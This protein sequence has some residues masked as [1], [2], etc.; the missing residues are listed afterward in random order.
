MLCSLHWLYRMRSRLHFTFCSKFLVCSDTAP[1]FRLMAAKGGGTAQQHRFIV[2]NNSRGASAAS[3][4][5]SQNA[6]WQ[7]AIMT[8]AHGIVI[9]MARA[10]NFHVN[11]WTTWLRQRSPHKDER[12]LPLHRLNFA[13]NALSAT[14]ILSILDT[15]KEVFPG[16]PKEM[17]L[18]KNSIGDVAAS[19]VLVRRLC[20]MIED[21]R[22][23]QLHLSHTDLGA[24]NAKMLMESAIWVGNTRPPFWLRIDKNS[25]GASQLSALLRRREICINNET[26]GCTPYR[27]GCRA[28]SNVV[29]HAPYLDRQDGACQRAVATSKG[30]GRADERTLST[31]TLK[32]IA[33]TTQHRCPWS[34]PSQCAHW[35]GSEPVMA[36]S[37]SS[38]TG[39]STM[40]VA[41]GLPLPPP[42]PPALLALPNAL[43]VVTVES[44]A[45]SQECLAVHLDNIVKL[46]SFEQKIIDSRVHVYVNYLTMFGWVPIEVLRELTKKIPVTSATDATEP[47]S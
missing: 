27:C 23:H 39:V 2:L 34:H 47:P 24:Q 40:T 37:G 15:I 9:N 32:V 8:Q 30:A 20:E 14:A 13:E 36:P 11:E 35:K 25:F 22:L 3:K 16:H 33:A 45:A 6:R 31:P 1:R 38:L 19:Q 46:V 5:V 28:V 18:F 43:R 26:T 17:L 12:A 4:P 42:K 29:L 10:S 41:P 7:A 44:P 21:G